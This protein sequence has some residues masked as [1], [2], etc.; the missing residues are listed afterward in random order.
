MSEFVKGTCVNQPCPFEGV[1]LDPR[2]RMLCLEHHNGFM[3]HVF[4]P[5][6]SHQRACTLRAGL[7]MRVKAA[8]Q[9]KVLLTL[10][11][12]RTP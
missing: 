2:G 3:R 6:E 1:V 9:G 7:F 12:V 11:P 8:I 4:I 10:Y 5:A